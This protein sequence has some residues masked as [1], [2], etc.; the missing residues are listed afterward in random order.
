VIPVPVNGAACSECGVDAP[1][2]HRQIRIA[3][4]GKTAL[5]RPVPLRHYAGLF[6]RGKRFQSIRPLPLVFKLHTGLHRS[7]QTF[8]QRDPL[9][10]AFRENRTFWIRSA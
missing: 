2:S 3:S 1:A 5:S 6:Q 7:A 9:R 10:A 4:V 8:S